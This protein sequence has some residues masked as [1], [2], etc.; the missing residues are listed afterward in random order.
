MFVVLVGSKDIDSTWHG[1]IDIIFDW[2]MEAVGQNFVYAAHWS[3]RAVVR[4]YADIGAWGGRCYKSF[5][6]KGLM[7]TGTR[8]RAGRRMAPVRRHGGGQ[9]GLRALL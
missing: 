6:H 5:P 2:R 4:N 8:L 1:G 9:S 7:S 3:C